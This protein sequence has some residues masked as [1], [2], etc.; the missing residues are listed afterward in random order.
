MPHLRETDGAQFDGVI[1]RVKGSYRASY[2]VALDGPKAQADR[3]LRM[4][5]SE[6]SAKQWLDV[7]AA[8]RGFRSYKLSKR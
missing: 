8:A 6:A 1:E 2:R 3:D 4:F 7:M 5:P